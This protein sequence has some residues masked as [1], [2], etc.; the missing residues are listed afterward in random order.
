M[1]RFSCIVILI[2]A[3]V[4]VQAAEPRPVVG[5]TNGKEIS[6]LV[7]ELNSDLFDTRERAQQHLTKSGK[8]AL[9]SVAQEA[10]T[11]SLESSTRA[12]NILLAWSESDDGE[13]VIPALEQLATLE[14]HPKQAKLA[15]ELLADVRENLALEAFK[16][17]GGTYLQVQQINGVIL[18]RPMRNVQ[19]I[20]G[21]DW[22][23][24]IEGLKLLE[25]MPSA[26]TVS[27]HSPPLGDEALEVLTR[28]PQLRR[29]ELYGAKQM[30]PEAIAELPKKLPAI[31]A[32]GIDV[33]SGA[34][35][36]VRGTIFG[37][38]AQVG[39]V[40]AGSAADVGGIKPNDIITN[41]DGREIKDFQTL[42]GLISR[43]EPG[44]SV[45]LSIL[46]PRPNGA[47]E[48]LELKVTFAEWGKKGAGASPPNLEVPD[49]QRGPT[50]EPAKIRLDRR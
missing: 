23:G 17:L 46:R 36:G 27:F 28:L 14:G 42:T 2:A 30:S 19:V 29:V 12:I 31:P 24:D 3:A 43:H 49:R 6:Q 50:P 39:E 22:K 32:D 48:A 10:R 37:E 34:F 38:N 44:D 7:T 13:L 9:E 4:A 5:A 18:P 11:G 8:A 35:L 45:T 33:R 21:S 47:P 26:T 16:K 20:I 1:R 40:V 41:L 15:K 25:Q